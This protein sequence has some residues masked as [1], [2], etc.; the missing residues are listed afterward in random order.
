MQITG[1]ITHVLPMKSGT[2]KKGGTWAA[3]QY[4]L[5]SGDADKATILLELFGQKEIDELAITEGETL[6]VTF[7]PQTSEYGERVFGRNNIT[8]VVRPQP[9]E[10]MV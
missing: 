6:T 5:E 9:H 4:V 8:G 3:Q 2:T 7:V 1:K 10:V